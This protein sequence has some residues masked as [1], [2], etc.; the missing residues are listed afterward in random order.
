[1]VDDPVTRPEA[2]PRDAFFCVPEAW[3]GPFGTE[4]VV[5]TIRKHEFQGFR[6]RDTAK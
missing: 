4:A 2:I 3:A 1:M 6:I 5:E